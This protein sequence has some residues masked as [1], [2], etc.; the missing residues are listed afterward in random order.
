[1]R[2]GKSPSDIRDN[3]YRIVERLRARNIEVLLFYSAELPRPEGWNMDRLTFLPRF[4]QSVP[5]D[6]KFYIEGVGG[7]L[8][9]KGYAIVVHNVLPAVEQAIAYVMVGG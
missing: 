7:H 2:L 9:S 4:L 8:N 3:L 6:P 1:M 5:N